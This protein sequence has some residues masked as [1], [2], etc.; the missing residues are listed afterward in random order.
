MP[1]LISESDLESFEDDFEDDFEDSITLKDSSSFHTSVQPKADS[2]SVS[3]QTTKEGS[4]K[5]TVVHKSLLPNAHDQLTLIEKP[6]QSRPS[7]L[8]RFTPRKPAMMLGLK[9]DNIIDIE[10]DEETEIDENTLPSSNVLTRA[11][12]HG[13]Q[14]DEIV[15]DVKYHPLDEYIRPKQAAKVRSRY[16]IEN[17]DTNDTIRDNGNSNLS[18]SETEIDDYEPRTKARKL[19]KLHTSSMRRSSRAPHRQNLT[20]GSKVHP[21]GNELGELDSVPGQEFKTQDSIDDEPSRKRTR[22]SSSHASTASGE[23]NSHST[24][25]PSNQDHLEMIT[26]LNNP[27]QS[28]NEPALRYVED[29]DVFSLPVGERYFPHE[30]DSLFNKKMPT[31]GSDF[32]I[33][34]ESEEVQQAALARAPAVPRHFDDFPKEN[35]PEITSSDSDD[36]SD[37]DGV[38]NS[39]TAVRGGRLSRRPGNGNGRSVLEIIDVIYDDGVTSDGDVFV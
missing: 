35:V 28:I 5:T 7:Q 36:D 34:E 29:L 17:I 2:K 26:A 1:P 27:N 6:S 20:Y 39:Q 9:S 30:N 3:P 22:F 37:D 33:Y 13:R 10:D 19:R 24:P 23:H 18:G 8:S 16:D 11:R 14:H 32:V 4:K 21:Q 38:G 25:P 12:V 15:Y 31:S